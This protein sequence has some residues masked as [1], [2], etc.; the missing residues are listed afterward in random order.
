MNH[1][2]HTTDE[3]KICFVTCV[4]D[5]E[6]YTR[7]VSKLQQLALPAGM[8]AE[9]LSIRGAKSIFAAY[10]QAV[11]QSDAKYKVYI[12]QDI[13]I[14]YPHAIVELVSMFKANPNVGLAGVSGC[15]NLP[16]SGVWWESDM[17]CG[18]VFDSH[19]GQMKEY[20]FGSRQQIGLQDVE[21]L[22]GIF[23]ATQYDIDWRTDL[24]KGWH[25]YDI[26]QSQE[27]LRHGYRVVVVPQ[28]EIWCTHEC[29]RGWDKD[30]YYRA[31]AVFLRY[32]KH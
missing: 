23:L 7:C 4:N 24:F 10:Q 20:N 17:L 27:F 26:S 2:L 31:R 5:E 18:A 21:A 30:A 28:S 14:T 6:Q 19:T 15:V 22:D 25:F 8:R 29:G 12:H 3:E 13:L 1:S 11:E 32:Y 9:T 16:A